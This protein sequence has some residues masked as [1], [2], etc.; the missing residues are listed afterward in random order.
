MKEPVAAV[1][2]VKFV[3]QK[4]EWD[5]DLVRG[6]AVL[7][8]SRFLVF[9]EGVFFTTPRTERT[10]RERLKLEVPRTN[11]TDV[12]REE[13]MKNT[14]ILRYIDGIERKISF[15]W[16]TER[17]ALINLMEQDLSGG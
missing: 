10:M 3:R 5:A 12:E 4:T 14:Y 8:V 17:K 9:K 11:I 16:G 1:A 2:K 7:T 6:I 13:R 15:R